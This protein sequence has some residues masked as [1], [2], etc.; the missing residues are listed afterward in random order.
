MESAQE[1][2]KKGFF[3][4]AGAV[5][6]VILEA[7][8]LQVCENHTIKVTKKD[9]AIGDLNDL[10][11]ANNVIETPMWRFIQHLADLRNKCDHKKQTEPTKE[12]IE[13]LIEGVSKTTKSLF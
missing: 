7:H 1:L 12:E 3:R 6:G 4:A 13:E 2:N 10:L 5:T 8:L 9:P 11:K